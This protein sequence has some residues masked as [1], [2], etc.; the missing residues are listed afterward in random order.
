M[1]MDKEYP[2][3]ALRAL[4]KGLIQTADTY[5]VIDCSA[6]AHNRHKAVLENGM[7]ICLTRNKTWENKEEYY[8]S[9]QDQGLPSDKSVRLIL[10]AFLGTKFM[11][12]EM[13]G[14]ATPNVRVFSW[15]V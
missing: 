3:E 6:P 2:T 14:I 13:W 8:L 12:K 10:L 9:I 7:S 15:P 11:A 4:G 5:P 1:P